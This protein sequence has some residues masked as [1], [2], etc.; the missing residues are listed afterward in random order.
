MPE[1][2]HYTCDHGLESLG[3]E[4]KLLPGAAFIAAR[5]YD[6]MPAWQQ[7]L[8]DLIWLTDLDYPMRD[9]LGLTSV[10]LACDRTR[11]RYRVVGYVPMRYTATRR[12]LPKRLRDEVESASGALPR[13][14]WVAHTPVPVVY[15]PIP[16]G[17]A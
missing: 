11:H 1:F 9:A 14:W 12:D 17:V 4:G 16:R 6:R 7:T 10:R 5:V 3:D 8:A 2:F 15:D 13:H